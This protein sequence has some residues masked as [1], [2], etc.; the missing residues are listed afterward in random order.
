MKKKKIA[1]S[2]LFGGSSAEHEVSLTS[3][4][5]IYRN[6]DKRKYDITSIYINKEGQ[7]RVVDSPLLPPTSLNA[8]AFHP[9]LPWQAHP[10]LKGTRVDIYFPVL[11]GPCGE[12]GTIQGLFEMADVPYVGATV[13]A[14]AVGMDKALAKTLF[15]TKDLPVVRHLILLEHEWKREKERF[16]QSIRKEFRL[17]FFVK[18]STLGSSIGITKVRDYNQIEAAIKEA[19]QFDR[20]IL[21]EEGIEGRELECSVLGNENPKTSL[22]GE[23][24]PFREFYDYRDKYIEGKTSFVIPAEIPPPVVKEVQRISLEAFRTIDCSGMARVDFFYQ[25]EKGRIWLN[26]INTIPGFTEIS[27]YPKLWEV[28]GLPFPQLLET[29]IELGL[30]KHRKKKRTWKKFIP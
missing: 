24:I 4:A 30:E 9:F 21:I 5:S 12:D 11:H 1:I 27:M 16:L 29:L 26:E 22:P 2:L 25:E 3:A 23:L 17:P 14:S 18:P 19:F 7:W 13:L 20:K 10:A 6:L 15:R 8:G 28:S